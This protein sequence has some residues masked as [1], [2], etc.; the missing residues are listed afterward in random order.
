[1]GRV[2]ELKNTKISIAPFQL[3]PNIKLRQAVN[4]TILIKGSKSP[5]TIPLH[6]LHTSTHIKN[7]A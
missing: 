6:L 2:I 3:A 5:I 4:V 1:M 7:R